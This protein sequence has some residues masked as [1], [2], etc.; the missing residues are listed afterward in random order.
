VVGVIVNLALFFAYHVWWPQGF[1]GAIE[2]AAVA[3]TA[4]AA[5]A[6]LVFKR[7][8]IEVIAA[9]ALLG[10]IWTTIS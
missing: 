7:N 4:L 6:L 5:I 2:W 8:V 3:I 9:S 10:L 1:A